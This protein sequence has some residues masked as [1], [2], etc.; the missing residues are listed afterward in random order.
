[1][2]VV[3]WPFNTCPLKLLHLIILCWCM[4]GRT[5]ITRDLYSVLPSINFVSRVV[6][7]LVDVCSELA[8]GGCLGL[9][10]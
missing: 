10:F 9:N 3:L 1:M 7:F 4:H 6:S 5:F 2:R 8:D